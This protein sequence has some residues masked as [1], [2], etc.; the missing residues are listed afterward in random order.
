MFLV[1]ALLLKLFTHLQ[2]IFTYFIFY[3]IKVNENI[4]AYNRCKLRL[5]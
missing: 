5:I 3:R 1:L 4:K 2:F